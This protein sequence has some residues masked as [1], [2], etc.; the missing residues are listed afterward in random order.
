MELSSG[1]ASEVA[2]IVTELR[3]AGHS[4][5]LACTRKTFPGTRALMVKAV[6]SGG[7]VMH[8]LGLSDTL[9]L[10][11]E[12]RVFVES[13]MD[14]TVGRLRRHQPEKRLVVEVT[15]LEEALAMASAGAEVLQLERFT[16]EAVRHC[17]AALHASR[18]H[19]LLAA[20][21]GVNAGNAVAYAS[22]GADILVSS[23]PYHAPPRDVEV[24]FSREL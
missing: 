21:G 15:S 18:L 13:D 8:R 1:V 19:P 3:A 14:D 16:P 5:P 4:Q 12:H 10:F 7:G 17:K 6:V 11:P 20:A 22:A 2:R 23:A 24:R 9:L